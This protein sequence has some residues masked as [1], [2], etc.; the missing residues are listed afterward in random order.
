MNRRIKRF[1]GKN[2]V[3]KEKKQY[4]FEEKKVKSMNKGQDAI[5]YLTTYGWALIVIAVTIGLLFIMMEG[6][7]SQ[8]QC[9][10]SEGEIILKNYEITKSD[11]FF[12]LLNATGENISD[13]SFV[14]ATGGIKGTW[15]GVSSV[16]AGNTFTISGLNSSETELNNSNI[17]IE[18][19]KNQ[20]INTVTIV[21]NGKI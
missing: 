17:V 8:M 16:S 3:Y 12:V 13:V 14:K 4:I 9:Y 5:E 2:N 11:S 6:Q 15:A 20:I 19:T 1:G 21:C 10:V 7:V 18:Y